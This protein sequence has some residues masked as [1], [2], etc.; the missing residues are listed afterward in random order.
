MQ[1]SISR[2]IKSLSLKGFSDPSSEQRDS[3]A[4]V[5][6][7]LTLRATDFL[8]FPLSATDASVERTLEIGAPVGGLL[9]EVWGAVASASEGMSIAG[10][11]WTGAAKLDSS[12]LALFVD[13]KVATPFLLW[14]LRLLASIRAA[15]V[16]IP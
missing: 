2:L 16:S 8:L 1:P 3:S 4:A 6:R 5:R 13:P 12:I 15:S 10:A 14:A 9:E 7:L 11:A